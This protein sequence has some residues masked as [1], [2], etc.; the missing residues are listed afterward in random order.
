MKWTNE[1]R[2]I[3]S[4]K[5]YPN[6]PRTPEPKGM[7]NLKQ[8][9]ESVGYVEPIA[10][11]SDGTILSGHRRKEILERLGVTDVDVRVPERML[12]DPECRE[13][14]IRLNRNIAGVWNMEALTIDFEVDELRDW[15]FTD[16]EL[17]V[18]GT[19]EGIAFDETV[20]DG[21]SVMATFKIKLPVTDA[22]PFEI[23]LDEILHEFPDA[24]KE[25][26]V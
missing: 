3:D 1:Q 5:D 16:F 25:K 14:V 21:E 11:N 10:I 26:K 23:R 17:G 15:G 4:L 18:H 7:A 12:T 13:V 19:P 6:N 2:P 24:V 8:S 9:I 20:T 22:E